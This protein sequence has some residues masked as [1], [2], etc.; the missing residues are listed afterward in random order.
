VLVEG[1]GGVVIFA[2]QFAKL[3]GATVVLTSSSSGLRP[4]DASTRI[5]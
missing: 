5:C 3:A 4:G 1:T 2:M